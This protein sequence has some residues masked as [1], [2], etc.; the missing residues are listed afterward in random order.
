[1]DLTDVRRGGLEDMF[2][3]AWKLGFCGVAMVCIELP[4]MS[5]FGP[6]DPRKSPV[7]YVI[8]TPG[9]TDPNASHNEGLK[10]LFCARSMIEYMRTWHKPSGTTERNNHC[11][12]KG[13]LLEILKD[14]TVLYVAFAGAPEE[15]NLQIAEAGLARLKIAFK[16]RYA[17]EEIIEPFRKIE[18]A[19]N[20]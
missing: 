3:A 1:V 2:S 11:T 8:C 9:K 15:V 13:G 10:T 12:R 20:L 19:S 5:K 16:R 7:V 17:F 4:R 6:T 14:G 18:K